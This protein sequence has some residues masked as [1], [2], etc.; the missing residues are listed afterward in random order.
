MTGTITS[1]ARMNQTAVATSRVL[2]WH[3]YFRR[4]MKIPRCPSTPRVA[5]REGRR[6]DHHRD[7]DDGR[8]ERLEGQ[9]DGSQRRVARNKTRNGVAPMITPH[10]SQSCSAA[11]TAACTTTWRSLS[12]LSSLVFAASSSVPRA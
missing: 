11:K 5:V 1:R 2:R 7:R 8:A 10:T 6:H 12:G 3:H 4:Q 9:A